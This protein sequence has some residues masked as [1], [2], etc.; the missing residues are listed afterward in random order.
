MNDERE[1]EGF[2]DYLKMLSQGVNRKGRKKAY[3][4]FKNQ[5]D[6]KNGKQ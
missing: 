6:G 1:F 4:Q 2:F 5:E 3:E